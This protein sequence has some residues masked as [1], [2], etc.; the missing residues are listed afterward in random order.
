MLGRA[1]PVRPTSGRGQGLDG[2][3]GL[4]DL[5]KKQALGTERPGHVAI[6]IKGVAELVWTPS[7][8][9]DWKLQALGWAGP[10]LLCSTHVGIP[11]CLALSPP[12]PGVP[13]VETWAGR[14]LP[15]L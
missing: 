1:P 10:T 14:F 2:F 6:Q 13:M 4:Q 15:D 9:G 7:Q 5:G 11:L 12:Y 3:W 8:Y